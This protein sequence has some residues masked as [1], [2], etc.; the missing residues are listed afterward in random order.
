MTDLKPADALKRHWTDALPRAWKPYAQLSRLDRQMSAEYF[1][2][3]DLQT[4]S[5]A[6]RELRNAQRSW[7][8]DRNSCGGSVACI[9]GEYQQ[10]IEQLAEWGL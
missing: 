9:R 4:S 7:L 2:Q 3:L 5:S 8:R 6:R 1:G 10:W